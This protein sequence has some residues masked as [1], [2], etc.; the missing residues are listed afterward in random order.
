MET[1]A[2][3][4]LIGLFTVIVV[5]AALLFGLWLAKSSVDTEFKD[6]EVVFNEAVSG[7]S[8]GSS[9]QYSG[10]KVGDVISLRL[11][12]KDPRR[13]LARIRLAGDTPVKED[14]QAKLA[15]TG[16][17]G[18]SIIQ[19]SGGT[20]QSPTLKGK[21][22]NLPT[23]VASPSPIARLLND[24]EDLMAGVSTLMHNANLMFSTENI[25]RIS[26]TL[27]HLEQTTGAIAD[28]RGDIRQTMQQLASVG[29]QANTMLEQTTALMRNANGL[30]NE[31]GKEALGSAEQAMKSLQESSATLNKLITANQDSLNSG[32]QGLNGLGPAVREMRETLSSLRTITTRLEAN[33][34]GYLLGSDKTK[35]FTP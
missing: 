35:E 2:H 20:P 8:Q 30:L 1:R 23:I 19:L 3:H 16:V 28:Q 21:D 4:V 12:P 31:H 26:N 5:T 6:Y 24:S 27:E 18:T 13:V 11:D 22:G 29:K 15:L 17:T 9:V 25:E 14:T 32:M 33:P 7:L 34:S 10:I